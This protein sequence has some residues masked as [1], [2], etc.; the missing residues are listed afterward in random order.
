MRSGVVILF[1]LFAGSVFAGG[2][3]EERVADEAREGGESVYR[4]G[5]ITFVYRG[6]ADNVTLAGVF[7]GWDPESE[8]YAMERMDDGSFEITLFLPAG[9]YQYKYVIDGVWI[10]PVDIPQLVEP[11]PTGDADDGFGGRNSVIVA[12]PAENPQGAGAIGSEGG[13]RDVKR[14]PGAMIAPRRLQ[15]Q[16]PYIYARVNE[17]IPAVAPVAPEEL[18]DF[19]WDNAIVYFVM[20]DRFYNG[21]PDNDSSYGRSRSGVSDIAT[22]HGGDLAGL[23]EKLEEGYFTELGI[24]AIWITSPLEQIHGWVAGSR[25]A[26][27]HYGYHG[28]Y[29]LDWT[30]LDANMGTED[31]LRRLMDGARQRGIQIVFDVVIN[32]TGYNTVAD[33]VEFGFGAWKGVPLSVDWRPG[34]GE[35][36]LSVHDYIDYGSLRSEEG[37]SRWWG[38]DWVRAGVAGYDPGGDDDYRQSLFFLPDIKTEST[39]AVL[40]P[41]I[42]A[43]KRERGQSGAREYPNFVPRD[44]LITWLSDWVEEYG[45]DGFR[46]DTAKHVELETWRELKN[47]ASKAYARYHSA[48]GTPA[49]KRKPFW[50]TGEVFGHG[51]EKNDYF[52]YGFDSLINF[53]FQRDVRRVLSPN[54]KYVEIDRLYRQYAEAINGDSQFSALSYLSSHDTALMIDLLRGNLERYYEALAIFYLLPGPIQIFYGD[55]IARRGIVVEADPTQ[56]TRSDM[57]WGAGDDKAMRLS[58]KILSFRRDNIAVAAGSHHHIASTEDSLVFSRR[59]F[60]LNRAAIAMTARPNQRVDIAVAALLGDGQNGGGDAAGDAGKSDSSIDIALYA[61]EIVERGEGV[62]AARSDA[63]GL[64][65]FTY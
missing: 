62:I 58:K 8:E 59:Y 31:D 13:E 64:L 23:A 32:H 63:D 41:P 56:G 44:Y 51:V 24:N 53:R 6:E 36:W 17:D 19:S 55:E 49:E 3:A 54:E 11:I 43:T 50:M 1:A 14:L 35:T 30:E 18:P 26:F 52:L 5:E 48:V 39:T 10:S 61:G 20:T 38:A 46:A 45:I 28:Y 22:F 7:S 47:S 16:R 15:T 25:G 2:G 21:N 37:W 4:A 27:P 65:L 40:L 29:H 12:H 60:D 9:E 34:E 42:L 33:S 57:P